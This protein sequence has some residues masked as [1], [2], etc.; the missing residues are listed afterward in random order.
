MSSGCCKDPHGH[1]DFEFGKSEQSAVTNCNIPQNL[2]YFIIRS[3][4][5]QSRNVN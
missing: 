1:V 5:I 4:I 2:G 3:C